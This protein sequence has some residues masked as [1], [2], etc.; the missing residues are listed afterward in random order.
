MFA[1]SFAIPDVIENTSSPA[2]GDDG[3]PPHGAALQLSG[4]SRRFGRRA[5]LENFDLNI[6]AGSFVA[7]V[8]R[9]GEGK[10]TLLRLLAG[11]DRP[12]AGSIAIDGA[13]VRGLAAGVTVMFQDARLLPWQS[14]AQN[15]GVARFPGW[16]AAAQGALAD[17]GLAERAD[18]WPAR[19]SGGQKQRVALARALVRAPRLLLLDE[20][21]GALD[22]LT[23]AD[24]QGLIARLWR[25]TGFT[26]VLVTHDVSEAVTL[27]D[28][29]LV[30]RQ[31]RIAADLAVRLA[32]P[33]NRLCTAAAALQETVLRALL[34]EEGLLF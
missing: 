2:R 18:D 6:E 28:R 19:L 1:T 24:M 12:D 5:V 20:P 25:R 27:A 15:V 31:G 14:V 11:L 34:G 22:A 26:A 9:S 32:R 3:A 30:L 4:V 13:E 10:S 29:I 8:G 7:I 17:V 23:R 21:L 33:R 16:R